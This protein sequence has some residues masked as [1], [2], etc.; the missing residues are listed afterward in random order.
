M[1]WLEDLKKIREL[2]TTKAGLVNING[3]DLDRLIAIV[4]EH[5]DQCFERDLHRCEHVW[6]RNNE[7]YIKHSMTCPY[8][9]GWVKS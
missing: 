9:D 2:C 3:N 7:P 6:P 1:R 5:E 8:S 4:E